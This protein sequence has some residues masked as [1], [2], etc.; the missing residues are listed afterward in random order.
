MYLANGD[1]ALAALGYALPLAYTLPG[2]ASHQVS[3]PRQHP[4]LGLLGR[5]LDFLGVNCQVFDPETDHFS[6]NSTAS[7]A[8]ISFATSTR[9]AAAT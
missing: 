5:P 2:A 9:T 3:K 1:T 7:T 4:P 8:V 6:A